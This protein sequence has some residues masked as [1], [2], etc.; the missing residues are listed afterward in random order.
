MRA[1]NTEAVTASLVESIVALAQSLGM[2]LIAEGVETES[3]RERLLALGVH[4]QQ[5]WLYAKALRLEALREL[6]RQP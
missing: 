2:G 6:L 3:Q 5:G 1:L 4:Q